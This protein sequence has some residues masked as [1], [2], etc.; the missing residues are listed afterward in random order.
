MCLLPESISYECAWD[1]FASFW[2]STGR[3][4][5]H[6]IAL[7]DWIDSN[8]EFKLQDFTLREWSMLKSG[9]DSLNYHTYLYS[10]ENLLGL[11]IATLER[12]LASGMKLAA[13]DGSQ[14]L[15]MVHP[16]ARVGDKCML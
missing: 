8:A 15:E 6:N 11:F 9:C 10:N 7:I 14:I 5:I 13:L 1:C 16:D 12:V 4:A 2:T 3:G